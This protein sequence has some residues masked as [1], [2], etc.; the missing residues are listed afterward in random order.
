M[1]VKIWSN[2]GLGVITPILRNTGISS[3]V[4]GVLTV[5][6]LPVVLDTLHLPNNVVLQNKMTKYY[7]E[8]LV[9][10]NDLWRKF[11][12]LT[13]HCYFAAGQ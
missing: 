13:T 2:T 9:V 1:S 8:R 3:Q 11:E 10:T 12:I 6:K 4:S 7:G 5:T